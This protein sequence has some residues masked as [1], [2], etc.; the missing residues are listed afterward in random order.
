MIGIFLTYVFITHGRVVDK[1][2]IPTRGEFRFPLKVKVHKTGQRVKGRLVFGSGI[3]L[4]LISG[5]LLLLK[6]RRLSY[7]EQLSVETRDEW[8][9][10]GF[11]SRPRL[12]TRHTESCR[13]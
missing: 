11:S 9:R 4:I 8:T 6:G 2:H 7:G 10:F 5:R 12:W 13:G 3:V 1:V